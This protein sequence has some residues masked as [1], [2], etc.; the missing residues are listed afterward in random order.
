[1]P[2]ALHRMGLFLGPLRHWGDFSMPQ[3]EQGPV[4]CALGL[5]LRGRGK[6]VGCEK[7]W[8]GGGFRDADA[9]AACWVGMGVGV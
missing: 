3:W 1:M 6:G 5:R 9:D 8:P 7:L 2:Q 4:R